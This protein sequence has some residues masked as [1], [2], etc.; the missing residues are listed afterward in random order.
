MRKK[1]IDFIKTTVVGGVFF[2]IPF[3]IAVLIVSKVV[4]WLR[5][6]AND[7]FPNLPLNTPGSRL[8]LILVAL[9][10]LAVFCFIAGLFAQGP[11]FRKVWD[12]LDSALLTFVPGYS[13]VKAF[14]S[15]WQRSDHY[16]ESFIPVLAMFDDYSQIAFEIERAPAGK[17]ALYLPG[18]P[19]PWSGTVVYVTPERVKR[20]PISLSEALRNIRMLGKGSVLA[21]EMINST[22]FERG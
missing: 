17:V 4:S 22:D 7:W 21:A 9:I 10:L 16:S 12:S 20:L 18:S 15:S 8:L 5:A 6:A 2:L 13:F 3:A 14:S 11:W 19:N 1:R